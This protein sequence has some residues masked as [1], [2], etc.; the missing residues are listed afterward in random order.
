MKYVLLVVVTLMLGACTDAEW[1]NLSA[2]GD[3]ADVSCFSGGKEVFRSKSTGKVVEM[4][5]GGW[6]FRTVGDEFVQTFADCFVTV[7]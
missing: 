3:S 4:T 2:Y 6:A 1:S 7:K 5:G